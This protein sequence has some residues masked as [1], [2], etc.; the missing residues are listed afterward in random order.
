MRVEVLYT[1]GCPGYERAVV[2]LQEALREA[3]AGAEISMHRVRT[4]EEAEALDFPG[5]PTI[6]IDGRDIEAVPPEA[7]GL[8]CRTYRQSDGALAPVPP[9][10][11]I[12]AAILAALGGSSAASAGSGVTPLAVGA[13]A[14]DFALP[15]TDGQ[16]YTLASFAGSSF[17][18]IAFLANHCPYASAWEGRLAALARRYAR[19]GVAFAAVC[20]SDVGRFPA[21]APERMA[22]RARD[23]RFPFPY[24]S[25]QTQRVARAVGAT[26][27]PHVFLFD[28]E[29]RV[30]YQG[31]IDSN[32]EDAEEAVP[33]VRDA[34]DALL[35]GLD[36]PRPITDPRGS[37]LRYR[38]H[39]LRRKAT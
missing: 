31:A 3:E 27:T 5:S 18:V 7:A 14:P 4:P 16:T 35:C 8:C 15:A 11:A 28:A 2:R 26:H 21:D 1:P 13:P 25:D 39:A 20:S 19:K 23:R 34:L 32:W 24:L 29:R 36:V 17:L 10:E 22:E 6:R 33:Y 9:R 37:R 38:A 12:E 30:R